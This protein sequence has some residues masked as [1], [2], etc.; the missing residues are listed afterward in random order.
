MT[1]WHHKLKQLTTFIY[2]T[3][4]ADLETNSGGALK[5][6]F[7]FLKNLIRSKRKSSIQEEKKTRDLNSYL[8]FVCS[9]QR[10][11]LEL[12]TFNIRLTRAPKDHPGESGLSIF[13]R[14]ERARWC[15][16]RRFALNVDITSGHL[17][18]LRNPGWRGAQLPKYRLSH[19]ISDIHSVSGVHGSKSL[20]LQQPHVIRGG[21]PV[22][23]EAVGG[24]V[25]IFVEVSIGHDTSSHQRQSVRTRVHE[26]FQEQF[27]IA[28][29]ERVRVE[30]IEK[31][32]PRSSCGRPC[33]LHSR[34]V[35]MKSLIVITP[36][37]S[38]N[39]LNCTM[40]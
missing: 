33:P 28:V 37:L 14:V 29:C 31:H 1:W 5:N 36:H 20:G 26:A 6:L 22:R 32:I 40:R 13:Q 30:A 39:A 9:W 34:C 19:R 24:N 15:F 25:V 21:E 23:G 8:T 18:L 16:R 27:A 4:Q 12:H 17:P 38:L 11:Q 7:T 10:K 2:S 35:P 3:P